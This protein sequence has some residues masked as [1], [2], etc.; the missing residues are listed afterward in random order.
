[1]YWLTHQLPQNLHP[2]LQSNLRLF[3]ANRADSCLDALFA[4]T[5]PHVVIGTPLGIGKPNTLLNRLYARVKADPHSSLRILTALSLQ[6][7]QPQPDCSRSKPQ[8]TSCRIGVPCKHAV[9]NCYRR[10]RGTGP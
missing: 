7:P 4:R 6:K 9:V 5:G 10:F 3:V 8:R 1:M 2:G